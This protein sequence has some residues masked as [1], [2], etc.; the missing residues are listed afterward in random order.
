[1]TH[2]RDPR[3][4]RTQRDPLAAAVALELAADSMRAHLTTPEPEPDPFLPAHDPAVLAELDRWDDA[5]ALAVDDGHLT[6]TIA[7]DLPADVAD[8]L[9]EAATEQGDEPVGE[10]VAGGQVPEPP[11]P[12][13]PP[14]A[15]APSVEPIGPDYGTLGD[16]TPDLGHDEDGPWVPAVFRNE[17]PPAAWV[18]RH[19]ERSRQFGAAR[20]FAGSGPLQDVR[21]PTGPVLDQLLAGSTLEEQSCCTGCG[22]VAAA[23]SEIY[24]DAG[25]SVPR[26]PLLDLDDAERVYD[27]ARQLDGFLGDHTAGTSVLAAMQ[28]AVELG[29][30]G[31]YLWC[32]GTRDIA[33]TIIQK[34]LPVVVG[35]RW[36][37]G[38]WQT[39]PGGLV[40]LDGDENGLGH[41]LTIVGLSLKGPQ[42]QPGP[43]FVWQ[44][45]AGESYGDG[46]FGYVHHRDLSTL[47]RGVGE[48]AVPMLT[49]QAPQ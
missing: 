31:G 4:R 32:F 39:G 34:R 19:D 25:A 24:A 43:Y 40:Q 46:G 13:V 33:Q 49:P 17:H 1:M 28:A 21:L 48:A 44:N 26:V 35:V 7:D 47:L 27:R 3:V 8:Q 45:S 30:F 16:G 6:H 22:T 5:A 23:N 15:P 9:A 18:S 36:R 10:W 20:L 14:A 37:S 38:M 12:P 11:A 2:P 41:C 29:L 42:G